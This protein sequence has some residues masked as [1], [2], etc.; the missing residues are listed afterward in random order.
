[1]EVRPLHLYWWL[2]KNSVCESVVSHN[3]TEGWEREKQ[4]ETIGQKERTSDG[5]RD[6]DL[7]GHFI[8]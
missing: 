5:H 6:Y 7:N 2:Q 1:M 8:T 4:K 3:F